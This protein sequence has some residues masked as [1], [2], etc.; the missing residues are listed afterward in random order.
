MATKGKLD[1]GNEVWNTV[2][3]LPGGGTPETRHKVF[4]DVRLFP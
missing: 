1:M 2:R 4:A 3:L